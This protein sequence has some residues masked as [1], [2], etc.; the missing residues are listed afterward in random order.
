MIQL[1]RYTALRVSDVCTFRKDAVS[2]DSEENIWRVFL[3]T[4]KTGDTVFLRIPESLKLALDALPL[5][6]NAAQDCPHYGIAERTRS[7]SDG[8]GY[9]SSHKNVTRK[10]GP[11]KLT[12]LRKIKWCGEGDL[13]PHGVTR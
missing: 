11:R 5:P 4:Q 10:N 1:L 3:Y 7:F 2:W 9:K 8:T 6:R 13:N 12:K